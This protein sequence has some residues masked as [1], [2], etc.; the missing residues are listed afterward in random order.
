MAVLALPLAAALAVSTAAIATAA[1]PALAD[2][3]VDVDGAALHIRCGGE[4]APGAPLVVLEAGAGNG[5]DTWSNVQPSIASFA[6]VC[7]YDRPTLV[8]G[9][10]TR[11]PTPSP[12]AVVVTVDRLLAAAGEPPPYVLA[13]HSYGGMIVRL[14]AARFPNRVVGMILIDSSHED[15]TRRFAALD[16]SRSGPPPATAYEAFDMDATSRA[17]A[18]DRWHASIPLVVLTR[19][20]PPQRAAPDSAAP[21][22][23]ATYAV[24][25]DLQKELATRSPRGEHVIAERSGHYIQNDEPQLVVGAVRRVVEAAMAR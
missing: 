9:S 8:R 10:P 17:L 11:P 7:A 5:A 14:F 16:P 21:S 12:T 4:R 15:Q 22:A 3:I 1:E 18:A 25:L 6:R 13:G 24:W 20:A 2:R 23:A 19:A